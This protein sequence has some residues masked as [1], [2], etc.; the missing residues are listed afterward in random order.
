VFVGSYHTHPIQQAIHTAK[1]LR[2]L[3]FQGKAILGHAQPEAERVFHKSDMRLICYSDASY[4]GETKSRSRCGGMFY[5]GDSNISA[6]NGP[7][8]SRSSVIDAVSPSGCCLHEREGGRIHQKFPASVWGPTAEDPIVTDNV[9]GETI[10]SQGHA[11][12][13]VAGSCESRAV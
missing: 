5:L 4:L 10:S 2:R 8:L 7:I 11:I 12:P 3:H 9:K 13:L 1:R 6:L